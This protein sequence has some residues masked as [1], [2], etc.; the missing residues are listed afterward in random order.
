[1]SLVDI[2]GYD[3]KYKVSSNGDIYSYSNWSKGNI[4]GTFFN[5]QGDRR[6]NL[7]KKGKVT[8]HR[9]SDLIKLT[10]NGRSNNSSAAS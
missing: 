4:L 7:S 3:G 10:Q 2:P 1:M 8:Q 6:V 5:R 9:I